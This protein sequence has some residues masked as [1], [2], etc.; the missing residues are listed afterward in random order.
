MLQPGRNQPFQNLSLCTTFGFPHEQ[1]SVARFGS[2]HLLDYPSGSLHAC[3]PRHPFFMVL[4]CS[5]LPKPMLT[6]SVRRFMRTANCR[7]PSNCAAASRASPTTL[8]RGHALGRLPGGSRYPGQQS[9]QY[10][11][12]LLGAPAT[13]TL[14]TP[15][16]A[17]VRRGSE[18]ALFGLHRS[19]GNRRPVRVG[20]RLEGCPLRETASLPWSS[21][22]GL[23]RSQ[24]H[25]WTAPSSQ[26]VLQCFDQIACVHMSGLSVRSHMSAG[27]D[28][29]RDTGSKQQ[30][31]LM[32]GHWA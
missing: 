1:H 21:S 7:P 15:P 28:G 31:G 23:K 25:M 26:G 9:R 20:F 8:R 3:R 2:P 4:R 10:G 13:L 18:S 24:A 11:G 29:F 27:Q 17:Q 14:W 19:R 32:E 16:D 30:G 12:V 6:R 22:P 5:S